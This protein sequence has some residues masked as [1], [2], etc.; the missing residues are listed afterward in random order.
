MRKHSYFQAE[1]SSALEIDRQT[2]RNFA[3]RQI[4]FFDGQLRLEVKVIRFHSL[5][6]WEDTK[7]IRVVHCNKRN[8][9]KTNGCWIHRK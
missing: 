1:I 2:W 3:H 6:W 8:K 4:I 5:G 7:A 9:Q